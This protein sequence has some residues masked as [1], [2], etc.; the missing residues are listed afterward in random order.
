LT[1]AGAAAHP[2]DSLQP[3]QW[4][5]VPNSKMSAVVQTPTAPDSWNGAK[6]I[7][8]S[9]SGGAYDVKRDRLVIWGGGHHDYSG[10]EVYVFDTP[11]LQW[12]RLNDYSPDVGGSEASGYYPDGKPRARHTYNYV[13]YVPPPTDR[14]CSLGG[15]AL[16]P[17]GQ[18]TLANV[19]CFDFGTLTWTRYDDAPPGCYYIGAFSAV[20]GSGLVWTHGAAG[21]GTFCSFDPQAPKGSQWK[22][23]YAWGGWVSYA[24]TATIDTK[25]NQ[26]VAVGNNAT[27]VWDLAAP[28]NKPVT[29]ATTGATAI[30]Q[31]SSP[32]VAYDPKSDRIVAWNTGADVYTLDPATKVWKV[33]APSSMAKVSDVT[34]LDRAAN[35][36]YGRFRYVPSH[37]VFVVVNG[38]DKNVFYY[39]LSPGGGTPYP[40][41]GVPDAS[42]GADASTTRDAGGKGD[43]GGADTQ[44]GDA[45]PATDAAKDAGSTGDDSGGSDAAAPTTD[46]DGGCSCSTV[47]SGATS[48]STL[49][50]LVLLFAALALRRRRRDPR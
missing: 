10:N 1:A 27:T 23:H 34:G 14:F 45:T 12:S 36:T 24:Y 37:N 11:T 26:F 28:G 5:E 9:W 39:K 3:G 50:M 13:A 42:T 33:H 15:A 43:A 48:A 16:F 46:G 30:E 17:S 6:S 31:I 29:L 25:R 41:A 32:G 44:T 19:D 47:A 38:I 40:D 2:L 8:S 7:I 35:G 49:S 20:D 18:I 21:N 22:K 4:Y